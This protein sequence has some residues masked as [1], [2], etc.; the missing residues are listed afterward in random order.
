MTIIS[1]NWMIKENKLKADRPHPHDHLHM[2]TDYRHIDKHLRLVMTPIGVCC[3]RQSRAPSI[4][5]ESANERTDGWT[6]GR[7]QF[8]N[9]PASLKLRG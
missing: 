3:T 5:R 1:F 6:D 2:P 9:L 8:Y 7:F 4:D